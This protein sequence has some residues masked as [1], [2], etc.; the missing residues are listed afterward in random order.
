MAQR[1]EWRFTDVIQI[2]ADN[3]VWCLREQHALAP[4]VDD[5]LNCRYQLGMHLP[6]ASGE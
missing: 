3:P 1:M 6:Q 2:A 4:L 5:A